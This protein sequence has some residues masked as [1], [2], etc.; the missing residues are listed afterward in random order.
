MTFCSGGK[1]SIQTELRA[2]NQ[3]NELLVPRMAKEDLVQ[4]SVY[5]RT[6][7]YTEEESADAPQP[8]KLRGVA[9]VSGYRSPHVRQSLLL[10]AGVGADLY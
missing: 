1:R 7:A 3:G 8:F 2:R 4:R 9:R 10:S 5:H 6:N